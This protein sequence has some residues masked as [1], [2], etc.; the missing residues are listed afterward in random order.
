MREYLE[1]L[2]VFGIIV[3]FYLLVA[4]LTASEVL[5]LFGVIAGFCLLVVYVT[6]RYNNA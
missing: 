6:W 1:V 5:T 3:G 4:V 2:A